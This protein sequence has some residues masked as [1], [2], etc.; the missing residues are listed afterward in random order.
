M[1]GRDTD[2]SV[3]FGSATESGNENIPDIA[4]GTDHS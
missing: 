2:I 3:R 1:T 4:I